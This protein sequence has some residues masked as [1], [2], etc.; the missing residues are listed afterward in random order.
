MGGSAGYQ[1]QGAV[2]I[3]GGNGA[4]NDPGVGPFPA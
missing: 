3:G 1:W 2:A 4:G